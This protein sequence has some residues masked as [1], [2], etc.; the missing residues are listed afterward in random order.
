MHGAG[1]VHIGHTT[2]GGNILISTSTLGA[3]SGNTISNNAIGPAGANLPTKGVMSLGSASPNNNTG[4]IIDN[5]N[6]FDFFQ[7]GIGARVSV[8]K[9]IPLRRPSPTTGSTRLRRASLRAGA[10][11]FRY[12]SRSVRGGRYHHRQ[13]YRLRCCQRDWN[14]HDQWLYERFVGFNLT[15]TST[16][17][18][19]SVQGN[20]ISGIIQST[21][22]T[23]TGSAAAFRGIFLASGRY[24]VG[25][26]TGNQIGSLD[27]S[28]TITFTES[29]T[30]GFKAI[31]DFTSSSNPISNNSIGAI[32]INGTGTGTGGFR[33][34]FLNTASA[35]TAT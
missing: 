23:G 24:D 8:F 13:Y 9:P 11:L 18:A 20:T 30:G 19:T 5:N 16:A 22:S 26:M 17:T 21:A 12:H 15:S 7:A 4:N 29:S 35:A 14:N 33:G 1:F 27:G 34:I 3:N 31:Y 6:I 2:A 28:S 10:D 32:T 25:T